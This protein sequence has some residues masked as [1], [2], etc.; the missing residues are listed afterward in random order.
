MFRFVLVSGRVFYIWKNFVIGLKGNLSLNHGD[1]IRYGD[2]Q[3]SSVY[4]FMEKMKIKGKIVWSMN[5]FTKTQ[6]LGKIKGL[7]SVN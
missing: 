7:P 4:P 3:R 6:I 2:C 1:M 5:S